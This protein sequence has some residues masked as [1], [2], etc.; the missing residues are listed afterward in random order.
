MQMALCTKVV[1]GCTGTTAPVIAMQALGEDLFNQCLDAFDCSVNASGVGPFYF[2]LSND[3][4]APRCLYKAGVTE[5][6]GFNACDGTGAC[7]DRREACLA[8]DSPGNPVLRPAGLCRVPT[9][10]CLGKVLPFTASSWQIT[11][12]PTTIVLMEI[13]APD[14]A[15][16]LRGRAVVR[17]TVCKQCLC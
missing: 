14:S 4:T 11:Q 10:G 7:Q 16:R 2:G 5:A 9:A 8:V 3:P 12:I 1:D 13:V 15:V 6:G 17:I